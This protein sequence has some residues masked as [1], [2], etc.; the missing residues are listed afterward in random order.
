[1]I[2][3]ELK[4]KNIHIEGYKCGF[5]SK[6]AIDKFK[7]SIKSMDK[8]NKINLDELQKK[9]IKLN[10]NIELVEYD[11]N[12]DKIII[13]VVINDQVNKVVIDDNILKLKERIKELTSARNK[14][15]YCDKKSDENEN[16]SKIIFKEYTKLKK[17]FKIPIPTPS[18]IFSNPTQYKPMITMILNNKSSGSH[19]LVK[20][21]KLIMNELS[22]HELSNDSETVVNEPV[23]NNKYIIPEIKSNKISNNEDTDDEDT[24][25]E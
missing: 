15:N 13:K 10:Y 18:E 9:Y 25:D 8:N 22:I 19:P 2:N 20:Y 11:K 23:I 21:F 5:N 16:I 1:M 7:K 17:M 6:M 24:E 4:N 14:V 12:S 3:N